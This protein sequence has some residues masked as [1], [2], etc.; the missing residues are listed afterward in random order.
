MLSLSRTTVCMLSVQQKHVQHIVFSALSSN[1][2]KDMLSIPASA[3]RDLLGAELVGDP[4]VQVSHPAKIEEGAPGAISFLG[5]LKYE[6]YLYTCQSSV[7]LIPKNFEPKQAVAATL[8]KV[9]DVYSSL[10]ILLEHF[11]QQAQPSVEPQIAEQAYVHPTAQLGEG[12][13]IEPF[14]YVGENAVLGDG[15]V[16]HPHSHIGRGTVL[17]QQVVLHSGAKIYH[18]CVLGDRVVVHAN[19][20]IGS[21]GFGF[22]PQA[23]GSYRKIP[24]LG[25]VVIGDDVEIGANCVVDRATMDSTRLENGVK[26][27]NLVQIAHNVGI[28]AHTVIAAQVGI[29]GSTQL[30]THCMVGGQVGFAGHLTIADHTKIQA[31][32]GLAQS[33]KTPNTALWGSP[34]IDYR[35]Y[36]RCAVVFRNLPELSQQ[37]HS[38]QQQL[39]ALSLTK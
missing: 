24:Q 34:A 31:Q 16:L 5:N 14:A 15:V 12:V 9:D 17:G 29:A 11:G 37:V 30:G 32:S 36:A 25:N 23:D 18:D 28:G 1:H 26:L 2:T 21:D 22:A 10:S 4:D 6:S 7:I 20:V 35:Q 38:L 19:A 27:D 8:L 33:V 13:H 3:L 39:D